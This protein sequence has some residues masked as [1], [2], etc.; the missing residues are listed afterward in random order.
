MDW[1]MEGYGR[2]SRVRKPL[3]GKII[4]THQRVTASSKADRGQ[5]W[6]KVLIDLSTVYCSTSNPSRKPDSCRAKKLGSI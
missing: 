4:T 1:L 5:R 6:E 3:E 2:S